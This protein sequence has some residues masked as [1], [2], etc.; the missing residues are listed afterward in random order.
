MQEGVIQTQEESDARER[1]WVDLT[2][3]S[4]QVETGTTDDGEDL[5]DVAP[6]LLGR[7]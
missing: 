7:R 2:K 4:R 5:G 6:H 3:L 1:F